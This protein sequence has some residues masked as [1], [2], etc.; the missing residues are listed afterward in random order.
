MLT[1]IIVY[2]SVFV[3][4]ILI[5]V[6]KDTREKRKHPGK[7]HIKIHGQD[8]CLD[9]QQF[10][11]YN[12]NKKAEENDSLTRLK[13]KREEE[14]R[15]FINKVS[16]LKN[17]ISASAEKCS[18]RVDKI[19]LENLL[20][21]EV[22]SE[23]DYNRLLFMYNDGKLRSNDEVLEYD[24]QIECQKRIKNYDYE[25]HKVN[26]IAFFAPFLSVFAIVSVLL[27][28]PLWFIGMYIAL[29]FAFIAGG[30]GM[31]I[32]YRIN[33]SNAKFY[34]MSDLDPRVQAERTKLGVGITGTI[35]AAG[36]TAHSA[37]KAIKDIT[38][39]DG[40]KEFK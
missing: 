33:I 9:Q 28:K 40:W 38:N 36:Y 21:T 10:D 5:A 26:I 12:R 13:Q 16:V 22:S 27:W 25:R 2:I 31:I 8:V 23:A 14:K 11:E 6:L 15:N 1:T 32:G 29:F 18:D 37:K 30:I 4:C 17:K 39:V 34:G 24:W 3:I 20:N 35:G 19:V 7:H